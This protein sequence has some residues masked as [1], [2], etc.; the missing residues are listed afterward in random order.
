MWQGGSSHDFGSSAVI[1]KDSIDQARLNADKEAAFQGSL[2]S[3]TDMAG[4]FLDND[5]AMGKA[6]PRRPNS[7]DFVAAK[8]KL[9]GL[10]A[11][12]TE[13]KNLNL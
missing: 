11:E 13:S 8:K 1:D 10:G 6:K 7:K 4:S 5:M 12:V 2:L 9:I 3:K